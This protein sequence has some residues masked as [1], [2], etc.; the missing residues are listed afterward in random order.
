M[1]KNQL[2]QLINIQFK[3]FYRE[4][5]ALFWSFIF[6]IVMAWGL[7]MTFSEKP[8]TIRNIAIISNSTDSILNNFLKSKTIQKSNKY[9]T[10][11][12][13]EFSID[14]EQLGKTIFKLLKTDWT[15]G[16]ILLKRGNVNLI[17]N[18]TDGQ[19][20]YNFDPHNPEAQLTY[21]QL[22]SIIQN[23]SILESSENI[24][25][26]T[27][28]GT[29]YIDFLIPGLIAMGIMSS[30]LWGISYGMIERRTKKLL[31]RMVATPMKKSNFLIAQTI[32]RLLITF[33]E[34]AILV[35]F[36]YFTFDIQIQGSIFGLILIFLAGNFAFI[37]IAIL[38]SS[39][40]SN[41]Q[42]GNGL[43]NSVTMPMMLLSGI[44]FSYNNFP[45]WVIS[46]VKW[47]PLTIFTD[48]LRSIFIEGFS[49]VQVLP[50]VTILFTIG[51]VTF[52]SGMKIYKW[53]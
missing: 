2:F 10:I 27:R 34:A 53:Y 1:K 18:E 20:K 50:S 47:L 4:P 26:L 35:F 51:F 36:A 11:N 41:M 42:V 24:Q 7:G 25:P 17:V 6:P 48:S 15:T 37:G 19:I 22:S 32:S 8:E 21:L 52:I 49:F 30:C 39:R 3:E 45:D 28:I 29:R 12:V 14:N 38:I 9:D 44:F 13:F 31:R 16:I 5:G 46:I 23:K 43:I 40:T 33:L